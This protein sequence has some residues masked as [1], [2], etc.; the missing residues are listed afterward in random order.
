MQQ[1]MTRLTALLFSTAL[2]ALS[3]CKTPKLPS[4]QSLL[5]VPDSFQSQSDTLNSA[6][7]SWSKIF[8]DPYLTT[9]IEEALQNNQDIQTAAVRIQ[10]ANAGVKAAKGALKP[11]V[12]GG[13]T[14]NLRKFGLYTMDGAGNA[15]TDIQPGR[16]VPVHLPDVFVGLQSSWELDAF[17]KLRN[18]KKA[19]L[20]QY[21]ASQEGRNLVQANLVAEISHAYFTLLATDGNLEVLREALTLQQQALDIVITQK[22]AGAANELAVKQF[23]AQVLNARAA[24]AASEQVKMETENLINFLV[25]RFPQPIQRDSQLQNKTL[26]DL[27]FGVPS[28]LLLNRPDI[29]QAELELKAAHADVLAARA[30]FFPT[31]TITGTLGTQA[32]DPALLLSP[33]SLAYWLFGSVMQPIFNRSAIEAQYEMATALQKNGL[34]NYQRAILSGTMEVNNEISRIK[35]L[36]TMIGLKIQEADLLRSAIDISNELYRYGKANYLELLTTQQ[37][38]LDAR[39]SLLELKLEQFEASI[40]LYKALGGGWR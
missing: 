6:S 30:A 5:S 12:A 28:Q 22:E 34:L 19:A 20:L 32:F 10:I 15:T 36:E 1:Y 21:F 35:N 2:L 37:N 7:I 11:F 27:Q 33:Q 40:N 29:R 16:L 18:Q 24:V 14:P 13:V 38:F 3:N 23:Q 39:L 17:K 26:P 25:G 8:N 9:L 31:V 4:E